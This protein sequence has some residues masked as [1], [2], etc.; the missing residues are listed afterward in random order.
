MTDTQTATVTPDKTDLLFIIDRSGSMSS[1]YKETSES[2][3]Q[4]IQE[5]KL[6]PGDVKFSLVTFDH[7]VAYLNDRTSITEMDGN[8]I[9]EGIKP[10]GYTALLD[11]CGVAIDGLG[12]SLSKLA[13]ADRP[14]K[15]IVMI[16]TDGEEN[17]SATFTREQI[18]ERIKHQT[19]KYSWNFLFFGANQDAI[20]AGES[21]GVSRNSSMSYGANADGVRN[22]K[23]TITNRINTIRRVG[24]TEAKE[25]AYTAEERGGA[26]GTDGNVTGIVGTVGQRDI[27][28]SSQ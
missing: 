6:L 23:G 3:I 22:T 24:N 4:I 28:R 27:S 12:I 9:I 14:D 26:M 19:E 11:A 8:K 25:L 10:R 5:Q 16:F 1:I 7:E 2:L 17:S 21:L 15:V 20:L 13:E 18:K